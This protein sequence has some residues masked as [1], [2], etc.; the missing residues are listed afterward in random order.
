MHN[1]IEMKYRVEDFSELL[2]ILNKNLED[3]DGETQ[4]DI[5]YQ[6]PCK[7]LM[8]AGRFLR[9]R[10]IKY[11]KHDGKEYTSQFL[12]YKGNRTGMARPE[13]EIGLSISAA[14][15][16]LQ[17]LDFT[18]FLSVIKT[19]KKFYTYELGICVYVCLD[20]VRDLGKFVE[21]EIILEHGEDRNKAERAI[22]SLAAKLNLTQAQYQG[23]AEMLFKKEN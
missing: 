5:Y 14:D 12:S 8:V 16:L 17:Q 11:K 19:R 20:D 3:L 13:L 18:P 23:Y 4:T 9:V 21:L 2:N 7:D 6:H 10:T 1:E 15:E 22:E